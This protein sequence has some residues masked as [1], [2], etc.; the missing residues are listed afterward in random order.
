VLAIANTYA[1]E[2]D[3]LKSWIK[4]RLNWLDANIPGLCETTGLSEHSPASELLTY[5]PNPTTGIIH[6]EKGYDSSTTSE[7]I[8]H[9]GSGRI[10]E[11]KV[12]P[13]GKVSFECELKEPGVYFF[14]LSNSK[15]L[16]QYGKI[17]RI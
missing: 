11:M 12:L 13:P 4:V 7:L 17:V 14:K 3:T 10:V 16:V 5:Y 15:R 6:F 9:D 8:L 1:A 2:L